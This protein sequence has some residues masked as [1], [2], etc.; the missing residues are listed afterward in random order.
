MSN[1]SI[2]EIKNKTITDNISRKKAYKKGMT[3]GIRKGFIRGS[4]ASFALAASITLGYA[5]AKEITHHYPSNIG[6]E[7]ACEAYRENTHITVDH[8]NYWVDFMKVA[9]DYNPEE[10]DLDS[11]IYGVYCGLSDVDSKTR[12]VD[13]NEFVYK[14]FI[15]NKTE[16]SSFVEYC[17]SRG[18]CEEVDGE[19]KINEEKYRKAIR[20]YMKEI[21][22][23]LES[24]QNIEEFKK[25]MGK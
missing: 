4:L 19:L 23:Q 2:E 7:A 9:E 6:Y 3:K 14:L 10:M 5:G 22:K 8:K 20:D 24:E 11:Y 18:L 12:L 25:G 21:R 15:L 1:I 13:M 16:Y 17:V